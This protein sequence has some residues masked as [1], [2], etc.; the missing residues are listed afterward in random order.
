MNPPSVYELTRPNNHKTKRI[1]KTVQSMFHLVDVMGWLPSSAY[2][3]SLITSE[4]VLFQE[5]V[6]G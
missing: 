4:V 5:V 2:C 1:T 6:Q 3:D